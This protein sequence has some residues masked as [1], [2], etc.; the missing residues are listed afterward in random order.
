M[1]APPVKV[2]AASVAVK[3]VTPVELTVW[4]LWVPP[5]PPEYGTLLLTLLEAMP[6]VSE[7]L[8]VALAQFNAVIAPVGRFTARVS[9]QDGPP[10]LSAKLAV[11]LEDGIPVIV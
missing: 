8:S 10:V 11:P 6:E 1:P 9:V 5:L 3:P 4:P 2:P 7:P